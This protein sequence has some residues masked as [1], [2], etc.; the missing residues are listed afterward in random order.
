M[1]ANPNVGRGLFLLGVS[2]AAGLVV[3]TVVAANAVRSVK[4]ANQTITVKGFAEKRI[5]SDWA[6]W[7]GTFN[8]RANTLAEAYARLEQ[9]RD[10]VL[11][12]L[13]AAGVPM[14]NVLLSAVGTSTLYVLNEKGSQT[15]EIEGYVLAQSAS[16]G[17]SDVDLVSRISKESTSLIRDGVEFRSNAPE[18]YYTELDGLKVEMLGLAAED[19]RERAEQL[20]AKSGARVGFLRSASQG[21]FQIT[22]AHSTQTSGYGVYDTRTIVKAIKSVVTVEYAI[23]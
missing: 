17:S 13:E 21:V 6:T 10:K 4:L 11:V 15:H 18:Y 7:T 8:A 14:D 5:R 12:R 22:S 16:V 20:A 2:L 3:S 1:N 23:R 19:A 9:D